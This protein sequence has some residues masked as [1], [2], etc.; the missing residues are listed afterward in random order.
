MSGNTIPINNVER[1]F[2]DGVDVNV[3][4]SDAFLSHS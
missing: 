3:G 1:W 4:D 2:K